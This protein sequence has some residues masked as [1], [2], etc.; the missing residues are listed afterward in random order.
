MFLSYSLS[1]L[2]EQLRK[3][4]K[5]KR[6][7]CT[8]DRGEE[9]AHQQCEGGGDVSKHIRLMGGCWMSNMKGADGAFLHHIPFAKIGAPQVFYKNESQSVL[10]SRALLFHSYEVS[11]ECLI[12]NEFRKS[13]KKKII[14][15]QNF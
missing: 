8:C 13:I 10:V 5:E 7:V 6:H 4:E 15:C 12:Y 9:D 14:I 2:L 1:Q 3:N 11:C